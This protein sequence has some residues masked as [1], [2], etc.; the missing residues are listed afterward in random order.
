MRITRDMEIAGV[1]ALELRTFFKWAEGHLWCA[2]TVAA[3][4]NRSPEAA[5]QITDQLVS[6]GY[7]EVAYERSH[8]SD[9]LYRAT[10]KG[11]GLAL[12]NASKPIKRATADRLVREL[13]ERV[14]GI[15]A[16]PRYLFWVDKVLAFGSYLTDAEVLGDVDVAVELTPRIEDKKQHFE[17]SRQ[18]AK[19]AELAGRRFPHLI[20]RL[21]WPQN[22]LLQIIK[23]KSGYLSIHTT[24]DEVLQT[25]SPRVLYQRKE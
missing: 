21:A 10:L 24:A 2:A 5:R 14:R 16:N 6:E 7:A 3:R 12:A 1:P 20:D 23:K 8:N 19:D 9:V 18:Y 13:L 25:A 15:N 17:M 22:E 11:G 4:L